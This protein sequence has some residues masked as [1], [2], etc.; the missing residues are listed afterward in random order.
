MTDNNDVVYYKCDQCD[1]SYTIKSSYQSHMR[2]KHKTAKAAE[3]LESGNKTARKKKVGA[4]NM[5]IENEHEKTG[6]WT[7]DLNS[8][9]ENKRDFSLEA[10]AIESEEAIEIE[11][12]AEKLAVKNH[13]VDWFEEDNNLVFDTHFSS[14]FA[15]SLRNQSQS[16]KSANSLAALHNEMMKKQIEKYDALVIRTTK[17]NIAAEA[18]KA[19]FR[20]TV[21]SLTQELEETRESWQTSSEIDAQEISNLKGKL[22]AQ[23]NKIDALESKNA[24]PVVLNQ[25]CTKCSIVTK[26]GKTLRQHMKTTHGV[27]SGKQCTQC[28]ERFSNEIELRK[29][30]K[31][32]LMDKHFFCELCKKTFK[33]LDQAQAH[34][35][36]P[37]ANIK[38]KEAVIDIEESEDE[39]RCNACSVSFSSNKSLEKHM[40]DEHQD[41]DCPK[42]KV[43]FKTQED[44]YKHA[45][46]CSEVIEPFM[47]KKKK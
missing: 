32:H 31:D 16:D 4:F 3:E 34:A 13:E 47:C 28:P 27:Q 2:L 35:A 17:S 25:K 12:Q 24:D 6:N 8:F 30:I 10:A 14:D 21:K 33:H 29:H 40:E 46:K 42:C 19:H 45:N 41:E 37:C 7:R 1:K 43:S 23:K 9:L 15:S 44:I 20:K 18:A 5:W 38:Q 11:L 39:H 22:A 36:K 26:D